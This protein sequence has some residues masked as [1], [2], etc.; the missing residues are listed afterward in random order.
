MPGL[1]TTPWGW[2]RLLAEGSGW[3]LKLLHVEAQHRT[4][5]Q[6]HAHRHEYWYAVEGEGTFWVGRRRFTSGDVLWTYIPAKRAHRIGGHAPQ[7]IT[8]VELQLSAD[9]Q[10]ITEGDL[11][12]LEDDY[13]RQ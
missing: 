12:R 7:G 13:H 11:T 10:E 6:T 2:H 8:L 5:L 1:V 3:R 4:S 9:G